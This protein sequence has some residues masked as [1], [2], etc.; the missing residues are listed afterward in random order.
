MQGL[1][2]AV[3]ASGMFATIGLLAT[4]LFQLRGEMRQLGER[5][6]AL[7]AA[8]IELRGEV[9]AL[10]MRVG[11]LETRVGALETGLAEVRGEVRGLRIAFDAH[12]GQHA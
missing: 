8:Q 3:L 10:A 12:V 11:A 6:G 4:A 2:I 7:E 5:M 1:T 9:T